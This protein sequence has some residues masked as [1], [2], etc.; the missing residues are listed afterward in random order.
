[1]TE[2]TIT[3]YPENLIVGPGETADGHFKRLERGHDKD[4]K[5]HPIAV[6]EI[7]GEERSLWLLQTALRSQ[8]KRVKPE[9][10]ELIR[11]SM[12]TEKKLGGNG[13]N[14]WPFKVTALERPP[15]T[16]D[17]N[18]PLFGDDSE[19]FADVAEDEARGLAQADAEA[20][21]DA[22]DADIPF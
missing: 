1:M 6:L 2:N 5:E 7:D 3:D 10:G 17:W 9:P 18:D 8:F 20:E 15:E 22:R 14:Y 12:A 13:F 21:R 11:V 16:V 19:P 4:G